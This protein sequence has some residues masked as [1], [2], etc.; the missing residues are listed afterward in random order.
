MTSKF[1]LSTSS[2]IILAATLASPALAQSASATPAA[3]ATEIVVTAQRRSERSRD[4][5]IS[6]T[7]LNPQQLSTANV[8]TLSDIT[9]LTPAMRFDAAGSN[10]Q[11]S[12]RGVGTAIA[13]SGA[14]PNV[15]IYVDGFFQSN[16]AVADFQLLKVQNIQVLEGP[17]G[18]LFGR[19]TTG[20]AILVT[21]ADPSTKTGL[22]GKL[23]YGSFNSVSAQ[24][25]ATFGLGKD[26]ALDIEGILHTG[27]GYVRNLTPNVGDGRYTNWS[28][29]TGLKANLSSNISVLL[30]YTHSSTDDPLPLLTSAYVDASGGANYLSKVS[31]AG[32]AIYG[33]SNTTGLPLVYFFTPPAFYATAPGT[34]NSTEKP[35]FT[36]IS[37]SFQGTIKADL[38]FANLTS[39]T[40]Y[41][42][43]KTVNRQ[44]LGE[45]AFPSFYIFIG[46]NDATV[47]QEFLLSSKPG[48]PL[49]W[50]AGVNYFQNRDT[51]DVRAALAGAKEGPFGGSTTTTKS[52]AAFA[53][54]TYQVT[55]Q[56]FLTAGGRYSH[57]VVGDATFTTNQFTAFTGYTLADGSASNCAKVQCA[58]GT[59]VPVN[60]LTNNSFTPR[61]VIRYKPSKESSIYASY[62]RGFKAGILN[63]GGLSQVP[64]KPET[65]NAFEVGYKFDNRTLTLD[66]AGFYYDY[67]NLQVS[68]YQFGAAIINN[69]ASS[70]IYGLEAQLGYRV[71]KD[72]SLNANAAYTHAR[73]KS[74]PG[75]P[76]YN[77]CDPSIPAAQFTNPL[78]C[79]QGAG[80]LA[81]TSID[82][83]GYH[84]QRSP[85]FTASIGANYGLD[86]A[87][88]RLNLSGN[89]YYS[90]SFYFD[91]VQQFK[92]DG[93]ETLSL[94]AQWVD[95]SKRFTLAVYGDNLTNKRYKTQ[96]L[97]NTVGVGNT[98]NPP[99]TWGVSAGVK[100]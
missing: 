8:T 53:D 96:V 67:K 32:K 11:P 76:F 2:F 25:Y 57:D 18:T 86:L 58:A 77:Y 23:S 64:V 46:V 41:R 55:D 80:T 81:Q 52:M 73:Y 19:N 99:A 94:R 17:Q 26:V 20:G 36:N 93:Y 90:S 34:I 69:A 44:E 68:S 47:S 100:F 27:D 92:Q 29:R 65:I 91:P 40:Q 51:W 78:Y 33:K 60:D 72:F 16:P 97:A 85:D 48:S 12:I 87:Q 13:T 31:A 50:S 42:R 95:P 98:W 39:Y 84:V 49:Q 37:D 66:F 74:F 54:L 56:L 59:I 62:T 30:R 70:E 61:V 21:T 88:G 24:G 10:V 14:G 83:S 3:E 38:G 28:V 4:V 71:N 15:G 43:D 75:A 6:V 7:T 22:E 63:V 5:P 9:K 79:T 89:L 1:I 82:A 35:V 45:T